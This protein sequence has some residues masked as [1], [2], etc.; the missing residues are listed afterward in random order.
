MS[1]RKSRRKP[2]SK[3]DTRKPKLSAKKARRSAELLDLALAAHRSGD[4]P[5]AQR[6]YQDVLAIDPRNARSLHHLG[7]IAHQVGRLRDAIDLVTRAT[8]SDPRDAGCWNNLGN[9]LREDGQLGEAVAA[10]RQAIER[11][12]HYANAYFNLGLAVQKLG[13]AKAAVDAFRAV[14]EIEP[15]DDDSWNKLGQAQ[16]DLGRPDDARTSHERAL[17]L[18]PR[19]ADAHNGLGLTCMDSGDFEAAAV[20][21]RRAIELE[22]GFTK[23]Y[24]NLAKSRRF[25][26]ADTSDIE[27]I[28]SVL[29]RPGL[30]LDDKVDLHFAVGKAM[31][32]CGLYDDAFEHFREAN[33]LKRSTQRIDL[34]GYERFIS[35]FIDVFDAGLFESRHDYGIEERRPIF[36]V[37]MPRSGT[38]LVEQILASHP[39]VF[40]A[41]ELPKISELT[42]S[43]RDRCGSAHGYPRYV[44]ELPVALVAEAA[45]EYLRF[46]DDRS[47]GALRVSDKLPGNYLHLGLIALLFPNAV[48]VD[49][50][51]CPPD[52]ILSNY[53]SQFVGDHPFSYALSDIAFEH[54]Q[55]V[56]LMRHWQA[57][58][59]ITVHRVDYERMVAD[60]ELHSRALLA[61]TG[62]EWDDR[63]LRFYESK[64]PVHTASN[65]QVRQPIYPRSV[66]RWKHYRSHLQDIEALLDEEP[67]EQ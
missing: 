51:R 46:T 4:L 39:D 42:R 31:D 8:G 22:P 65:W 28:R 30:S 52:V 27:L 49:C 6:L 21:Y 1:S 14:L 12:A 7:L 58:L 55:Y 67:R 20:H 50:R 53:F 57:V 64:R 9:M 35:A 18:N 62:L 17:E 54:Q 29:A 60:T 25:D 43:L 16:L 34:A 40:G 11:R 5:G 41:G 66:G 36:I 32:D 37:G 24:L 38:T 19:S 10:Y 47:G 33:Q 63:C 44:P 23:V 61:A 26:A 48:V 45:R 2:K 15:G 3:L 59:P 56:R 13:E